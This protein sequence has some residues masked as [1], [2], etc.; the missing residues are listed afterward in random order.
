MSAKEKSFTIRLPEELVD[1]I[2]MRCHTT[3]RSRNREVL[4]LLTFAFDT[5]AREHQPTAEENRSFDQ[6]QTSEQ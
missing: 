6:V 3:L 4:A 5:L 1:Q 2:D